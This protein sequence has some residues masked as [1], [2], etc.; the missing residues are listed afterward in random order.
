MRFILL[1]LFAL[2]VWA[3]TLTWI[4]PTERV[5]GVEILPGEISHYDVYTSTG[6]VNTDPI[7]ATSYEMPRSNVPHEVWVTVTD[8]DGRESLPSEIVVLPKSV[9]LPNAPTGVQFAP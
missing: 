1:M 3:D 9:A 4:A 2:P 6:Q 7:T 8:T 5:D